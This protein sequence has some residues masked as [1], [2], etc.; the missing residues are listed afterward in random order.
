MK[1][2]IELPYPLPTWNRIMAM[3]HFQRMTL[4]HLIHLSVSELFLIEDTITTQR[5]LVLKPFLTGLWHLE[6]LS[7]IRPNKSRKLLLKAEKA[8]LKGLSSK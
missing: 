3:Q 2:T 1:I 5:E 6:Y 4:R 8:R 7:M